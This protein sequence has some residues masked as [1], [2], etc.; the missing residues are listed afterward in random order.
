V[1]AALRALA[2]TSSS[3]EASLRGFLGPR[4]TTIK[5][6]GAMLYLSSV[7]HHVFTFLLFISLLDSY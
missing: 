5:E 3:R 6:F 4:D 1:H 7:S 2:S